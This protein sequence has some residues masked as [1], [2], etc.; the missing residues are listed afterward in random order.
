MQ[1]DLDLRAVVNDIEKSK[2]QEV[3]ERKQKDIQERI[4]IESQLKES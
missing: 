3:N 1:K 4:K 2:N